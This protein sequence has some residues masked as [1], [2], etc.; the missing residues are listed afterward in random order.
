MSDTNVAA[1]RRIVEEAFNQGNLATIDELTAADFVNHDPSDPTEA[2]GPEG[3]KAFITAYRTA[4]PDLHITIEDTIADGDQVV[5]RWTSRGTHRG[6]L[7]GLAPTGKQVEV[8]GISIDRYEGDKIAESWSNWDTLGLM[9]QLGAAPAPGSLGEKVGLQL[10][11]LTA[12]RQRSKAG[13]SA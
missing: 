9:R 5:F 10:Q 7:M 1:S 11:H 2:H 6:D 12:R 3:A 4:F 13:V 8:T